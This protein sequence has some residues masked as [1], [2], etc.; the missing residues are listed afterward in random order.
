MGEDT[1]TLAAIAG[2]LS[3]AHL[4][5]GAIPPNLLAKLENGPKGRQY[6]DDLAIALYD[7]WCNPSQST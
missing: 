7:K 6:I 5:A 4:G 1:D 2:A 3:G